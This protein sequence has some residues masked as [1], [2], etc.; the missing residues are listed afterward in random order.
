MED[1]QIW[2]GLEF[3]IAIFSSFLIHFAHL[4]LVFFFSKPLCSLPPKCI[5]MGAI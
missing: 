3:L 1:A 4:S 5:T 2:R